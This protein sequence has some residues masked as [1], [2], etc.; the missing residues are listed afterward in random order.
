MLLVCLLGICIMVII[1]GVL[2]DMVYIWVA[3]IYFIYKLESNKCNKYFIMIF[4]VC[5][6][7]LGKLFR[8][9]Y[10]GMMTFII[11]VGQF[12]WVLEYLFIHLLFVVIFVVRL[13]F[14]MDITSSLIFSL[15]IVSQV[16]T[17]TFIYISG[18]WRKKMF[19]LFQYIWH[20]CLLLRTCF[21]V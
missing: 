17:V 21:C 20:V 6:K 10:L 4:S 1:A 3:C 9:T 18:L 5:L 2:K 19:Y 8:N 16:S 13:S 12:S 11:L 14:V 7:M 15:Q